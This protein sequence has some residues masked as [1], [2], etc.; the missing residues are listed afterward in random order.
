M[1]YKKFKEKKNPHIPLFSSPG[2]LGPWDYLDWD[3]QINGLFI[4]PS[5][6]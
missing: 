5:Y 4:M 3:F 1:H 6:V 2:R